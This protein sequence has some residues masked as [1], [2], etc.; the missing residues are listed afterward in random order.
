MI[1]IDSW[2]SALDAYVGQVRRAEFGFGSHDC[3]LFVVGAI[4]AMT[5]TDLGRQFRGRYKTK[6]GAL[7]A[8]RRK[9]AKD[10]ADLAAL[11]LPEVHPIQ[12]QI[13]DVMALPTD[14]AFG[15]GL[16]ICIGER[17][18]ILTTAGVESRDRS[19]ATRSFSV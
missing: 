8:M 5:G 13:G 12:A 19:F 2:R 11:F 4:S 6:R 10:M 1:R 17:V 16:G 15:F 7:G 18:L 3:A 9:G 14:D